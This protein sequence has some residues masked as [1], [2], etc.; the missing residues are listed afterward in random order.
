MSDPLHLQ[1]FFDMILCFNA[2]N[3][4]RIYLNFLPGILQLLLSPPMT[5]LLFLLTTHQVDLDGLDPV[6]M[7]D[8]FEYHKIC[9]PTF[10]LSPLDPQLTLLFHDN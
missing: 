7:S 3:L 2:K 9:F 4:M 5:L 10:V 6:M 8:K 1:V